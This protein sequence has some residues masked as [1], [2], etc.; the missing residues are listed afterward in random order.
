MEGIPNNQLIPPIFHRV[1]IDHR[2]PQVTGGAG[3]LPSTVVSNRFFLIFT[4][5]PW[6]R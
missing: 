4:K 1:S 5:D 3:I 2:I 6:G